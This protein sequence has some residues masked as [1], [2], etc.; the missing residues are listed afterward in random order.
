VA[1]YHVENFGCRASQADGASIAAQ[2]DRLG[3]TPSASLDSANVVILNTC[4]VTA[5]ADRQA[6]AY[7]RRAQSLNPAVRVLVTGCYAQRA[8]DEVAAL[9]GVDR[10]IGN[11]HK[12][13]VAEMAASLAA[14]SK[15]DLPNLPGFVPVDRLTEAAPVLV[16]DSFAH[17]EL[18][19]LAP[20][21]FTHDAP[22]R[23]LTRPN[24]KVQDGC[25]NRCSFCIIPQTRGGS[26]SIS[27]EQTELPRLRISSVEPMDWTERLLDLYRSFGNG[28]HPRL[29]RH[30]HLPLQSG[31]DA[32]LRS[33][34]RRYRPWHYAAKLQSIREAMPD[35][36]IGADVMVGFPGE[37]DLLFEESYRF[38]EQQPFTYLHLFPFSA[39]PGTPAWK[40]HR[41]KPVHGQAVHERMARLRTLIDEKNLR[42]RQ[43]FLN[44]ELSVVTLQS[45]PASAATRAISDNFLTVETVPGIAAN[46]MLTVK[47]DDVTANGLSGISAGSAV[48]SA[49]QTRDYDD[50][51]TSAAA[52]HAS[53]EEDQNGI[54]V[55]Q[56][57]SHCVREP[58]SEEH[59]R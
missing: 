50:L 14:T 58:I 24:L 3:L 32:V 11:S 21:G 46:R 59:H 48:R 15:R 28:Q 33:M 54:L 51:G 2:L 25:G 34:Y 20:G 39:R 37:T 5:E 42:F 45:E 29:A 17:A 12:G 16:D 49:G 41:E 22:G 43:Q 7:I 52:A 38:I 19:F 30:A 9:A 55:G 56:G 1:E 40:L 31:S 57:P 13:R 47:V 18:A 35:A 10:V 53:Y 4:S 36:A 27:L 6:R 26:R 44:R 23:H 8:P